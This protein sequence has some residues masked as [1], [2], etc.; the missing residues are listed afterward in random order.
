MAVVKYRDGGGAGKLRRGVA[1]TYISERIAVGDCCAAFIERNRDFRLPPPPPAG[2][3]RTG[4]P[5]P[6]LM[7][8]PGTGLA[9][10]RA[11][12]MHQRLSGVARRFSNHLYFGCRH[13]HQDFLY[14]ALLRDLHRE[15]AVRLRTAFSR[16]QPERR[17]VQTCLWEDRE[18]VWTEVVRGGRG[19]VYVCGDGS[20]M[21][22]D[23]NEALVDIIRWG[24]ETERGPVGRAEAAALLEAMAEHGR[25]KRDVW[26]S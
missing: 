24:M 11:F 22:H 17:Y 4:P 3:D 9:P 10:F 12:V 19:I 13:R 25:Y 26:V 23:V 18:V 16:D 7:I 6:L 8:G 2:A 14:G 20:R 5:L 21:A 1:S 15:G